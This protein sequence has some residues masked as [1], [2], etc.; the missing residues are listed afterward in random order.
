MQLRK[1]RQDLVITF[2]SAGNI[3]KTVEI[4]R[5]E[6]CVRKK[7]RFLNFYYCLVS[8]ISKF[9]YCDSFFLI[10]SWSTIERFYCNPISSYSLHSILLQLFK[11]QYL[12]KTF[13]I[14]SFKCSHYLHFWGAAMNLMM[15]SKVNQPTKIASAT[16][17]T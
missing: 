7:K 9:Y 15:Y 8:K 5:F 1:M 14:A 6:K 16:E 2:Y 12:I 10:K 4:W 17:K 13:E 3:V 11:I